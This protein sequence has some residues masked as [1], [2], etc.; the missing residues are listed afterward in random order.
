MCIVTVC[1]FYY[2]I[3]ARD[4]HCTL[5]LYKLLNNNNK[6]IIIQILVDPR[7]NKDR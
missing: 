2:C 6:I 5:A 4:H 7:F 1:M 3:C